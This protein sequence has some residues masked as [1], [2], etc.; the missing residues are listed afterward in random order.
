MVSGPGKVLSGSKGGAST[1]K[2]KSHANPLANK[3]KKT[4]RQALPKEV[5]RDSAE[6]MVGLQKFER[7]ILWIL[8]NR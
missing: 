3:S 7:A 4:T 2:L 6:I 8:E 5:R 1:N